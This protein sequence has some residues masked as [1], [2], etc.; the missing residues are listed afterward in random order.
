MEVF[1]TQDWPWQTRYWGESSPAFRQ[2]QRKR[3]EDQVA[4]PPC[5][6]ASYRPTIQGPTKSHSLAYRRRTTLWYRS[7]ELLASETNSFLA[8]RGWYCF[9]CLVSGGD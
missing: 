7:T 1:R 4:A 2:C 6:R 8:P 5:G 3:I 9:C